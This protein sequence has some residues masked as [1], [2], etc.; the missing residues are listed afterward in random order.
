MLEREGVPI[1]EA[2]RLLGITID[3]VRAR[4][5]RGTLQSYRDGERRLV[6]VPASGILA[7]EADA[8]ASGNTLPALA[9][10]VS[11]AEYQ[12]AIAPYVARIAELSERVGALTVELR[13][14][15]RDVAA[16]QR[17]LVLVHSETQDG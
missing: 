9:T 16:L 12:Q 1:P 8:D 11:V 5:R 17:T 14:A 13:Q 15:R 4:I 7:L 10:P 2:A 6:V 3:G